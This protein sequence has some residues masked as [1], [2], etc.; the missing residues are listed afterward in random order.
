MGAERIKDSGIQ[1]IKDILLMPPPAKA[2]EAVPM[3]ALSCVPDG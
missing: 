3:T 1:L 2:Q